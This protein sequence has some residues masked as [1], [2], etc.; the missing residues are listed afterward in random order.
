[1]DDTPNSVLSHSPSNPGSSASTVLTA[2][3]IHQ[4]FTSAITNITANTRPTIPEMNDTSNQTPGITEQS[5]PSP[6][7]D[8]SDDNQQ[9]TIDYQTTHAYQIPQQSNVGSESIFLTDPPSISSIKSRSATHNRRYKDLKSVS[10]PFYVM[11]FTNLTM[12]QRE[13][14]DTSINNKENYVSKLTM[15]SAMRKV[16]RNSRTSTANPKRYLTRRQV[17]SPT[18]M[19]TCSTIDDD[20]RM[21][22]STTIP[23]NRRLLT[24][25]NEHLRDILRTSSWNHVQM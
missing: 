1:L 8:E 11:Y 19:N 22:N 25:E 16:P 9:E 5:S 12:Q 4:R 18:S 24:I 13:N 6:P 20:D 2:D 21:T 15:S 7:I 17:N 14:K 3:R 23:Y 10:C